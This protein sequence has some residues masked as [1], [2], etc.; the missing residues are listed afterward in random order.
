MVVS[1]FEQSV[2]L[3]LHVNADQSRRIR[4]GLPAAEWIDIER[5]WDE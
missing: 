5:A 3:S 2:G 1:D 4:V